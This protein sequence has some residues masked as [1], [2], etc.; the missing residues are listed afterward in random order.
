MA[1][2]RIELP[3]IGPSSKASSPAQQSGR[4]V[5]LYP[6]LGDPDAK[7]VIALKHVPGSFRWADASAIITGI[8]STAAVRGMHVMGKR[9]FCVIHNYLLEITSNNSFIILASLQSTTGPVGFSAN[10]NKLVVGDGK[11][12][13]YDFT[14]SALSAVLNEGEEQLQGYWPEWIDG[15]TLYPIRNSG[16]Y[17]YSNIDDATTVRGLAFLSAEG[18][19]DNILRMHVCNRQIIIIGEKSTEWHWDTGDADNPFQRI[20]G[21]FVEHGCVGMRASCKFDNTVVM[22]GQNEGGGG[23]IFRLRGAGA[24]PEII[25]TK[26]VEDKMVKALFS[27]D[28]LSPSITMFPYDDAGHAF[29]LV[30]TP[31]VAQTVNNP[32][33]PSMTW[34]YDAATN[35]WHERGF[36]NP[37]TGQF[38]RIL[39]DQHIYWRG[40]HYTGA[41]NAPHIYEQSL[42]YYRENTLPLVKFRESAG[43]LWRGG[44]TFKVTQVGIEMEVGVGRD[45]GVQGSEPLIMLQYRWGYGPWSN[46]ITRSIGKIGEGKTLVRF[47]P[48]GSGTDFM[49]RVRISDPVRVTL[50]PSWVDI[51]ES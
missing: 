40:R 49:V 32:A 11:Y 2:R 21:G 27:E 9:A 43:P 10:N 18:N 16:T 38:E 28:D 37:A 24:A 51:E 6:E 3:L 33:Q 13:T 8:P 15:T 34:A 31:E 5:N 19:P 25:S 47:G 1:P 26:A 29:F 12:W 46:E 48:C 17:Y 23:R 22:V 44:K 50:L 7:G 30:N 41:Y 42:D 4:T 39:G 14:T 45:G 35:M 36:T 20:S